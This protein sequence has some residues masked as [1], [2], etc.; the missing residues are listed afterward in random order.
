MTEL[1]KT[2]NPV[3][4]SFVMALL[5]EAGIHAFV[6]DTHTSILEGSIGVL[7]P[8]RIMVE[9]DRFGE[10]RQIVLDADLGDELED[11]VRLA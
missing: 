6:A 3:L 5:R 7:I 2:T 10:S 1:L 9:N 11:A 4:I 8:Q